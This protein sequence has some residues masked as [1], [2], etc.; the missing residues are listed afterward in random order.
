MLQPLWKTAWGSHNSKHIPTMWSSDRTPWH[1]PKR[2]GNL[3][4]H[5]ILQADLT[6]ALFVIAKTWKGPRCPSA[7]EWTN[8]GASRQR[9]ITQH[10]NKKSSQDVKRMEAVS[11]LLSERNQSAKAVCCVIPAT[12]HSG[13]A[14]KR[15]VVARDGGGGGGKRAEHRGPRDSEDTLHDIL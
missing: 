10:E 1:L 2:A 6:P 12:R 5:K 9:R 7:G 8:C 13:K 11:L 3:C 15:S 4:P 14:I